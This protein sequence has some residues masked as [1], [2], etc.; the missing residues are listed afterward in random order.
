MYV[1]VHVCYMYITSQGY[2][3]GYTPVHEPVPL[4]SWY[5]CTLLYMC[6]KVHKKY[7]PCTD[8]FTHK[9]THQIH[10][11][12]AAWVWMTSHPSCSDCSKITFFGK[13][14]AVQYVKDT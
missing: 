11:Q 4:T 7:K 1:H 2:C 3:G 12:N 9:H 8:T 6:S 10:L 14:R 13:S 5:Q